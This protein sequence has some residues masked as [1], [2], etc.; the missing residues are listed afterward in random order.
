MLNFEKKEDWP[1]SQL[2]DHERCHSHHSPRGK[3]I[4]AY[5]SLDKEAI[6]DNCMNK[7]PFMG[8]MGLQQQMKKDALKS[9]GVTLQPSRPGRQ[10]I[11]Q[12]GIIFEI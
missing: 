6:T 5:F 4:Y 1:E 7:P 8:R 12:K 2:R 9:Q 11:K 10:G 3:T